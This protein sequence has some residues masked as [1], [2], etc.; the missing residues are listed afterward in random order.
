V[1]QTSF[2]RSLRLL[3]SDDFQ[4]VFDSAAFRIS[5]QHLL[6]L[7]CHNGRGFPRLGLV[8]AKKHLRLAVDRNRIKR[9]SRESFRHAQGKL[10]DLDLVV[11]SRNGLD[12]LSNPEVFSLLDQQWHR[13]L[14]KV[15]Q[16]Q[17]GVSSEQSIKEEGID[18]G[19]NE[20]KSI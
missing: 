5:H 14:K 6:L 20:H 18:S 12:K 4:Q 8:I 17:S 3:N 13:L 10:Q 11:L 16:K 2:S 7:A 9:L 19:K 1:K 15:R